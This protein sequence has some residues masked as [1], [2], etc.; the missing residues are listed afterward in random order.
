MSAGAFHVSL[1]E[2]SAAAPRAALGLGI[3]Q[4]LHHRQRSGSLS[5]SRMHVLQLLIGHR[6]P[7]ESRKPRRRF[8]TPAVGDDNPYWLFTPSIVMDSHERVSLLNK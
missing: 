8:R 6:T 5:T 3:A 2:R 1:R 7:H 4:R